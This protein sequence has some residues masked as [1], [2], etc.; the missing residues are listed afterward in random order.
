MLLPNSRALLRRLQY[1]LGLMYANACCGGF[2]GWTWRRTI[3]VYAA[4]PA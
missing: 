4:V 1:T 2:S 3:E